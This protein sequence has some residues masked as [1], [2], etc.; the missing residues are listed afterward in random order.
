MSEPTRY[1]SFIMTNL[2]KRFEEAVTYAVRVHA[3]QTRKST[4][5][6]YLS[7]LLA[8]A[9][10][11][12]EHG[13]TEDEAIAALLHDA[14]EDQGGRTRLDDIRARFGDTV[15]DIVAGCSDTFDTPKPPWRVRKEAYLQHLARTSA[16]VRLVSAA[17]KWHN[18]TAI[19]RDLRTHGDTS[20]VWSR[21]TAGR[22]GTLWYYQ[23]LARIFRENGPASLSREI[24][25]VLQQLPSA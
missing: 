21:F 1:P 14:P 5:I 8:V 12:L 4:A 9:G 17:D 22:E 15:A 16:P 10:C 20:L 2:T 3:G 11:A 7:H 13:A 18:L 19:A 6:P 24:D 25:A 23:N